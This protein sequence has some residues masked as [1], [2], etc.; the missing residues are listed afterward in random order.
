MFSGREFHDLYAT[1]NSETYKKWKQVY[2]MKIY[3]FL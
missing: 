3:Q 1:Q 2:T